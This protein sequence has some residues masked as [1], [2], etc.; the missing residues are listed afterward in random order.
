M[1]TLKRKGFTLVE[2]LVVVSI[3]ALLVAILLP[4]VSAARDTARVNGSK[5]NSAQVFK[6][7]RIYDTEH[8]HYWTGC[9]SGLA[10]T[11]IGGTPAY[12]AGVNVEAALRAWQNNVA[13]SGWA[14]T[15]YGV[16]W[17]EGSDGSDFAGSA[18]AGALVTEFNIPYTWEGSLTTGPNA[19]CL[20]TFR[21]PNTFTVSRRVNGP[22][23]DIFFA[24]KDEVVLDW[25]RE[26]DC[27]DDANQLCAGIGDE[28][29]LGQGGWQNYYGSNDGYLW[30][31]ASSYCLSPASMFNPAVFAN[32][33][34]QDPMTMSNGFRSPS[35]AQARYPSLKT[36]LCEHHH[37]Q[38]NN[39]A[40]SQDWPDSGRGMWMNPRVA[41]M[42]HYDGVAPYL[43]NG[44]WDSNP[45]VTMQDGS[46]HVKGVAEARRGDG[47]VQGE[48]GQGLWNRNTADGN[49]GYFMEYS[50]YGQ[51]DLT[52]SFHTHTNNGIQGRDFVGE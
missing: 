51:P 16:Q 3:I 34:W 37:L 19:P 24:P 48:D 31:M 47:L 13:N 8:G 45:V 10:A 22:Y 43:F 35:S 17:G 25:L 32:G 2:L 49:A 20:G 23:N 42:W 12:A 14:D 1:M 18:W 38:N 27:F 26:L 30:G 9:P 11:K 39:F 29:D 33:Q 40:G 36:F 21:F 46:T 5:S 6:V 15:E 4:A 7:H 44:H 28:I 41:G 50:R 52:T